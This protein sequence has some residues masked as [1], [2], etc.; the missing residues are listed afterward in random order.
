MRQEP[1]KMVKSRHKCFMIF[2]HGIVS[3]NMDIS[4]HRIEIIEIQNNLSI[5]RI[6]KKFLT[7][8]SLVCAD[9]WS[10]IVFLNVHC[11]LIARLCGV[12]GG[13]GGGALIW[14]LCG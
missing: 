4:M 10:N 6:E 7:M 2:H 3:I 11:F 12:G 1:H 13:G 14:G 9:K 8:T 5:Y